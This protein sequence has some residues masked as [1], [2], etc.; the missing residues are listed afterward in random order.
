MEAVVQGMR[1]PQEVVRPRSTLASVMQVE[2]EAVD[3][4]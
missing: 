1:T 2:M 4:V 3:A